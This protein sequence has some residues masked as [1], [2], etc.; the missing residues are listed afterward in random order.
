M[1]FDGA[2]LPIDEFADFPTGLTNTD[3]TEGY[4]LYIR[5][6]RY[7]V[8][9][10]GPAANFEVL[11]RTTKRVF[12]VQT[13]RDA[14]VD[15]ASSAGSWAAWQ[16]KE[17]LALLDVEA[18][19][20]SGIS[21]DRPL[22]MG[23][24]NVTPDS[25]SDGGETPDV[26]S[27]IARGHAMLEAGAD[28][29]DVGGESTRPG[30]E[31]V[32]LEEEIR[33]VVSVIRVL[34]KAG[35]TVSIDTRRA[36]VMAA[37]LDAGATIVNDI[38]ALNGDTRSLQTVADAGASIVLMHMQGEPRTMQAN[39]S[40][41]CAPLD[42]FDFLADRVAACADAGIPLKRVAIDP[43]IGFGK[44]VEHN[45]QILGRLSL[46]RG[47]GCA[48]VLGVSRKSFIGRLNR[49]AHAQD[50]LAGSL[51]AALAGLDQGA[52]ILRVHDVLETRQAV[53]TWTAIGGCLGPA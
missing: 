1:E 17:R 14:L 10:M 24:V 47:L 12:S 28:I 23:I 27:A 34:A 5:H 18:H 30:A 26:E 25:F 32:A 16:V 22:I 38:T 13:R 48:I 4:R 19:K 6:L 11:I 8:G 42:V 36:P 2:A 46:L 7:S 37:A 52:A 53:T 45:L 31:P 44:T 3:L 49:D 15:W 21:L 39:P 51:A 9:G 35:A 40:Y 50:R 41:D 29:L 33:R 43:G 20:F